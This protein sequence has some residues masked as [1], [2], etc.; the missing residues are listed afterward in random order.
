[1]VSARLR[2]LEDSVPRFSTQA[3]RSAG[4]PRNEI[5]G[6]EEVLRSMAEQVAERENRLVEVLEGAECLL[7]Y[8]TVHRSESGYAWDI[9]TVNDEAA[10]KCL[11][12]DLQPG[13]KYTDAWH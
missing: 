3:P 6:L 4:A 10:Q 7:W 13:E 2:K 11:P 8:A 5:A 1:G 12:L 9:A